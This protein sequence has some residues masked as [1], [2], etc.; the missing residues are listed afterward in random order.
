MSNLKLLCRKLSTAIVQRGT[1]QKGAVLVAG[2]AWA[3]VRAMFNEQGQP[4]QQA[5][6]STPV[7]VLGWRELPSAGDEI[8]EVE[9]EV[10]LNQVEPV[11]LLKQAS[12]QNVIQQH[13]DAPLILL[14]GIADVTRML[15]RREPAC[16]CQELK[17][18]FHLLF[19]LNLKNEKPTRCYLLFYCASYSFNMF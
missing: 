9:S 1:L 10:R 2:L 8:I 17:S 4:I 16:I 5:P 12:L 7:E 6:P 18:V 3:K 15:S 11:M 19:N 13:P 14:L